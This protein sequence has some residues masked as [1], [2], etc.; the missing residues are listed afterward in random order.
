M[1]SITAPGADLDDGA[2]RRNAILTAV[3]GAGGRGAV[4]RG[5]VTFSIGPNGANTYDLVEG[6]WKAW[7]GSWTPL[8][9]QLNLG[10]AL[11]DESL[12]GTMSCLHRRC[13]P[14]GLG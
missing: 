13:S 3:V 12:T 9:A 10:S 4:G 8:T 2:A 7:T 6:C 11:D 14:E 5:G 1:G